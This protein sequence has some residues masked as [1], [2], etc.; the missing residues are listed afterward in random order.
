MIIARDTPGSAAAP[1]GMRP[2]DGAA[3]RAGAPLPAPARFRYSS[4]L[5]AA[6]AHTG[7]GPGCGRDFLWQFDQVERRATRRIRT[8]EIHG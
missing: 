8:R 2:D 5:M 6:R 1:S 7:A 4:A 3:D